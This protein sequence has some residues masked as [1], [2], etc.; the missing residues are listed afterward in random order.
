MFTVCNLD[1]LTTV[2]IK[3]T[4]TLSPWMGEMKPWTQQ[5]KQVNS[6]K[7]CIIYPN[8]FISLLRSHSGKMAWA[9]PE[10]FWN[11]SWLQRIFLSMG[12]IT[13]Y[14]ETKTVSYFGPQRKVW[15]FKTLSTREIHLLLQSY[16]EPSE[17]CGARWTAKQRKCYFKIHADMAAR[18]HRGTPPLCRVTPSDCC[19]RAFR[20]ALTTPLKDQM[21]SGVH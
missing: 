12:I 15:S 19:S 4:V 5:P 20:P 11:T 18:A 9:R 14:I 17:G 1:H 3:H 13:A 7:Y 8:T 2:A 10:S 16:G 6:G 21:N